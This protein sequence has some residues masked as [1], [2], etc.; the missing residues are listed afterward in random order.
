[1]ERLPQDRRRLRDVLSERM[2]DPRYARAFD[3]WL[4]DLVTVAARVE[5]ARWAL[6]RRG[7]GASGGSPAATTPA[8]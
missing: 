1:M 6:G 5:L 8:A 2:R 4:L 3:R 7:A